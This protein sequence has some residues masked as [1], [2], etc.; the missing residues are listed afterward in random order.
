[1][2]L[3]L[4]VRVV[5]IN[6]GMNEEIARKC[7]TLNGYSVFIAKVREYTK[8]NKDLETGMK[9]AIKYCREQNILRRFLEEN[10][11]EALYY[12]PR[13]AVWINNLTWRGARKIIYNQSCT[14][15]LA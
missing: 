1:M 9:E 8:K 10:S 11:T 3:E 6:H 4:I 7:E 2:N 13:K 14:K 15:A 12:A 5:N